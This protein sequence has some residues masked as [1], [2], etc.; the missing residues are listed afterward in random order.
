MV[1]L[2]DGTFGP[3]CT[4][5]SIYRQLHWLLD[6]CATGRI[7]LDRPSDLAIGMHAAVTVVLAACAN[8]TEVLVL[9]ILPSM[10]PWLI[11]LAL[12]QLPIARGRARAGSRHHWCGDRLADRRRPRAGVGRRSRP[13]RSGVRPLPHLASAGWLAP[14]GGEIIDFDPKELIQP[15]KSLKVMSREIQLGVAAAEL[16]WQDAGLAEATLDPDRFGVIG[17]AGLLYCELEELRPPFQAWMKQEDFDIHR[18]S[19]QAMGEMYP[20]WMLKYLPNMPACHIGIRYDARGPNNT[21][22]EGDVSSLLA[23][24]EAADVIRRDQADV[25]IAGGTGSRLNITDFMWHARSAPGA[26]RGGR[27]GRGLP[28]VRRRP[29]RHGLRRGGGPDRARK[30]RTR[31]AARRAAAGPR[32]RGGLPQRSVGRFAAAHGRRDS[33]GDSGGAGSGGPGAFHIGHV[34]AHGN[35]T[36]E[37]DPVEAQAIR[38]TLGDVPVTAPKS[39]FGNLGPAAA[40]SS[41]PSAC[42]R[43]SIGV[44]PPTLNYETPDPECPVNVVTDCRRPKARRLSRSITTRPGKRRRW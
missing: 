42:W 7:A 27:P 31:R 15:R 33:P 40:R 22:T 43:C 39:F 19:R 11:L 37:D 16:A 34:N 8:Y 3:F 18:W 35:S 13:R 24:A 10:P 9:H 6:Q 41:W 23:V 28:A 14:F 4:C 5:G 21:I 38:Q 17:G 25:M 20:L 26:R 44:V 12:Q 36:R 32:G 30:P 29:Q 2:S 1:H